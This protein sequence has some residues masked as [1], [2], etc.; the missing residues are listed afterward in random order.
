[1][2]V[3]CGERLADLLGLY[4]KPASDDLNKAV[5][6]GCTGWLNLDATENQLHIIDSKNRKP[7]D[8]TL[9]TAAID[10]LKG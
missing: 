10:I 6:N 2:L 8:I 4:W 7:A 5:K 1:M 9:T 3:E